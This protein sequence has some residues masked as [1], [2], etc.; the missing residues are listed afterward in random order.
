MAKENWT[1]PKDI[2]ARIKELEKQYGMKLGNNRGREWDQYRSKNLRPHDS[3]V[4]GVDKLSGGRYKNRGDKGW[5]KIQSDFQNAGLEVAQLKQALKN[6]KTNDKNLRA[7]QFRLKQEERASGSLLNKGRALLSRKTAGGQN[8]FLMQREGYLNQQR[9]EIERLKI[10]TSGDTEIT[11]YKAATSGYDQHNANAAFQNNPVLKGHPAYNT[12][13]QQNL[14]ATRDWQSKPMSETLRW[15]SGGVQGT[16]VGDKFITLNSGEAG[17]NLNKDVISNQGSTSES[18]VGKETSNTLRINKNDNQA[19]P[20][21][22][23]VQE[24]ETRQ[25]L[26]SDVFTLDKDGNALGVMTRAQRRAWD[27]DPKNQELMRRRKDELRI[28]SRTYSSG[29]IGTGSG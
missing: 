4:G 8:R 10:G 3:G 24:K 16:W 11:D 1:S 7:A 12:K 25:A 29:D 20:K 17:S 6:I 21:A 28:P 2:Q 26:R 27:A 9:A 5:L 14:R 22:A 19:T 23:I 15:T 13:E 18:I